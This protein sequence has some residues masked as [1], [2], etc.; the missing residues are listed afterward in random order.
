MIKVIGL[1]SFEVN[2][3][4]YGISVSLKCKAKHKPYAVLLVSISDP[5]QTTFHTKCVCQENARDSFIKST[6]LKLKTMN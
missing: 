4:V 5:Q 1:I 6:Q 3:S 2:F